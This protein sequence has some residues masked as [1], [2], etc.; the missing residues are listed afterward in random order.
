MEPRKRRADPDLITADSI[1]RGDF[2]VVNDKP[3]RR[4]EI[5]A[6]REYSFFQ[7][8]AAIVEGK[9]VI[10]FLAKTDTFDDDYILLREY[11]PEDNI[12]RTVD[13][14]FYA[15]GTGYYFDTADNL[16]IDE[17]YVKYFGSPNDL[18]RRYRIASNLPAEDHPFDRSAITW[19]LPETCGS[20]RLEVIPS[21]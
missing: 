1:L 11:I 4:K 15:S 21:A 2:I 7:P 18:G 6:S 9:L 14:M 20:G 13:E 5:V 3:W 19:M 8:R 12:L 16:I 17:G 10:L